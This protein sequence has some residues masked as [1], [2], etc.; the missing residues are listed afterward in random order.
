MHPYTEDTDLADGW[1][2]LI[3][4]SVLGRQSVYLGPCI[5]MEI[6]C[7]ALDALLNEG[8]AARDDETIEVGQLRTNYCGMTGASTFKDS[9]GGYRINAYS[10]WIDVKLMVMRRDIQE[11][12][13][14]SGQQ[15]P[16]SIG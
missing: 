3:E 4:C 7:T 14:I 1:R 11:M 2:L 8:R 12:Q 15:W 16:L 6:R 9:D 5:N 13:D 10:I